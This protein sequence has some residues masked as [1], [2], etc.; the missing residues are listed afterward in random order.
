[1]LCGMVEP[2]EGLAHLDELVERFPE[3]AA[4]ALPTS[5]RLKHPDAPVLSCGGHLDGLGFHIDRRGVRPLPRAWRRLQRRAAAAAAA[6]RPAFRRPTVS[7]HRS[8]AS[9]A[10]LLMFGAG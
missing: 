10:G 9:S 7:I 6:V 2:A 3:L 4:R 1:M 5:L 8:V